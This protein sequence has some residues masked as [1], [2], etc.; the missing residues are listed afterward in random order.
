VLE[1]NWRAT[2]VI[3]HEDIEIII[4]NGALAKAPTRNFSKPSP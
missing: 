3:P 1:I 4:P 2:K